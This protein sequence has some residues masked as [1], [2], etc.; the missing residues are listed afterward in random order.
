R[1]P[2]AP[3]GLPLRLRVQVE[4]HV[5][6]VSLE[7]YVLGAALSEVTPTGETDAAVTTIFEVQAIIARTY[8]VAH[9]G[10]HAG[11]GFDLCDKTHCQLYQPGR[12]QTSTFSS[13]ARR[14]VVATSRRILRY[15]GRAADAP[16]HADC[17]GRTTTAA[18]VWGGPALPYLP[19]RA[20]NVAE[21]THRSWQFA[22]SNQE[23]ST[24]LRKDARTDPGGPMRNVSVTKTDSS[25][26]AAE[27][28]ITGAQIRRVT[29]SVLRS[30]VTA[31]RGARSL[32]STRFSVRRTS[33]G[34]RLEG[35]GFG[36]G[37]GLC[38]V[39]AIARARRGD[40][41]ASILAHYY[42]GAK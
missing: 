13:A 3:S 39:G 29:G 35:T 12:I 10:R 7:Q 31:D 16:F 5:S 19:E 34:F 41:V 8:A 28:E 27:V 37:V 18:S 15:N 36:H 32:M 17:G 1:F 21:G 26:R 24:I 9:L 42:P 38:Q 23:W 22:A 11:E 20:D 2:E 6:A 33:N 4:G 40:P 25:G 14:A 30:V